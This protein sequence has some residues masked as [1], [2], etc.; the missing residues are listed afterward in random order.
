MARGLS[1][2][3]AQVLECRLWHVG[4]VVP[5]HVGSSWT[6]HRTHVPCIGR[7]IL[8]RSVTR[9]APGNLFFKKKS[10]SHSLGTRGARRHLTSHVDLWY[11]M[12][13]WPKQ[14]ASKL[15]PSACYTELCV[16][17]GDTF[18]G[19]LKS[20][21]RKQLPTPHSPVMPVW[22]AV[23]SQSHLYVCFLPC[24]S[25]NKESPHPPFCG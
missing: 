16:R 23:L 7:R 14:L 9:E 25:V 18:P 8:N 17:V 24:C 22:F 5:W 4:L 2:C 19:P 13:V 20:G 1:S 10:L 15:P 6:R 11:P 3:G 12:P 21:E